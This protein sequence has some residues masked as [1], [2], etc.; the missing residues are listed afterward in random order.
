MPNRPSDDQQR[1]GSQ[2]SLGGVMAVIAVLALVLSILYRAGPVGQ[3]SG[4]ESCRPE[5]WIVLYTGEPHF[6]PKPRDPVLPVQP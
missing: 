1:S 5:F 2:F 6:D 3:P 4:L